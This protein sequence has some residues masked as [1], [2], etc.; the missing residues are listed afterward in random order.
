M[1]RWIELARVVEENN[2][3]PNLLRLTAGTI[4]DSAGE[5]LDLWLIPGWEKALE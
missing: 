3:I 1:S 2:D 5:Y 4:N